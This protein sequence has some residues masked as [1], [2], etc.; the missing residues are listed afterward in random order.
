[1]KKINAIKGALKTITAIGKQNKFRDNVFTTKVGDITIDT[2][3]AFDTT[4]WET[5]INRGGWIIVE[6]YESQTLA[7]KGHEKWVEAIEKNPKIQLK[8]INLWDL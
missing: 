5:G 8:D 6:Q 2:Y 4:K 3:I 7:K 1:M